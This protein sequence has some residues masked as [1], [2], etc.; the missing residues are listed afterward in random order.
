MYDVYELIYDMYELIDNMY[1]SIYDV[2]DLIDDM[3][4]LIYPFWN[5]ILAHCNNTLYFSEVKKSVEIYF[6]S[7]CYHI[8]SPIRDLWE[9]F[10]H[11]F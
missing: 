7:A 5:I 9:W 4:D 8:Y 3:P 6:K 2:Y 1:D 11:F 10:S